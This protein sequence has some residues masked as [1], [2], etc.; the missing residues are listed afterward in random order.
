MNPLPSPPSRPDLS[1]R[2]FIKRSAIAAGASALLTQGL[3]FAT[4]EGEGTTA[5]P[6]IV[7]SGTST[8]AEEAHGFDT[9]EEAE[10]AFN[11]AVAS[12]EGADM[13]ALAALWDESTAV[14]VTVDDDGTYN[15]HNTASASPSGGP[16]G[17][18]ISD[19]AI[20]AWQIAFD[21]WDAL[22]VGP[23]PEYPVAGYCYNLTIS[24]SATYYS[25]DD[26]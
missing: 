4:G 20:A 12:Y 2:T 13:E 21:I 26:E 19:L 16:N 17:D 23:P 1:R 18:V 6:Q 5:L 25:H 3:V 11:L 15:P 22:R 24:I 10:A 8:V 14:Y 7:I 9:F